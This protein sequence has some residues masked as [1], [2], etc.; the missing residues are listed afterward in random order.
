MPSLPCRKSC[1]F[2]SLAQN[3]LVDFGSKLL[4]FEFVT[5]FTFC[6]QFY[7]GV[8]RSSCWL[9]NRR[10]KSLVNLLT[11]FC[12]PNAQLVHNAIQSSKMLISGKFII[13]KHI[14]PFAL[15]VYTRCCQNLT[16]WHSKIHFEVS[17]TT[18]SNILCPKLRI[19]IYKMLSDLGSKLLISGII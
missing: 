13:S 1:S 15:G 7:T 2:L 9:V 8:I 16:D 4:I 14:F 18:W 6:T 3:S 5:V 19:Y 12:V 11:C 10:C 17:L